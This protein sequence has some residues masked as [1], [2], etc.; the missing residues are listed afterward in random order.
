MYILTKTLATKQQNQIQNEQ[1]KGIMKVLWITNTLFPVVCR[2]LG[3][4][5]PVV[6]GWMYSGAAALCKAGKN[7]NLGI[8]SLYQGKKLQHMH[9]EGMDY[10][11]VPQSGSRLEYRPQWELFWQKVNEQFTPDVVHIHGTEYPHGLA[12]VNGC[13]NRSVVVSIQGL[14]SVYERYYYGGIAKNKLRKFITFRDVIKRDSIFK[15]HLNM[16]KRG[17]YEKSLIGQVDHIIGRTSWDRAHV[18]AV[19]GQA[20]YHFC[21]ETLRHEFYEHSWEYEH[22]EKHSI[23]LSQ[24]YYPIKGLQQI[25]KA[26]PM[27]LK[28]FPDAKVYV[29]GN[30]FISKSNWR[31]SGFG[32]YIRTLMIKEGVVDKLVFTGVLS[33]KEMCSRYLKSNLFVCPSSIENS[34][35]SIGEAQL[36]GVPCVASF[37]GGVPD[38]VTHEKTGLLYRFEEAE[39]L[40]NSV[41]RIFSD[42]KFANLISKNAKIDAFKRHGWQ[43]NAKYL[44]LIYQD[45]CKK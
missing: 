13:G 43:A 44:Y 20:R 21:N 29:A 8:A 6:G 4:P 32:K 16:Q 35:N 12:F 33:E 2:E 19:N 41:C 24:A 23:F 10:F 34:P 27:I 1:G 39:M 40:A 5:S 14:I 36:L 7:I 42:V 11:L 22:C 45:I 31:L 37:V 9:L 28:Y 30:N 26:L 3:L 25:I 15:Q 17:S 18:W 38:M